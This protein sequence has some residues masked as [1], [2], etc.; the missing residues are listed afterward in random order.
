M[1]SR[2][3]LSLSFDPQR[4]GIT[5]PARTIEMTETC[6]KTMR[7]DGGGGRNSGRNTS[8]LKEKC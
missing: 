3:R 4:L 7:K 2:A 1:D 6:Y 5:T 8:P